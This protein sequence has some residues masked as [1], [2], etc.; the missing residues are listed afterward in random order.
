MTEYYYRYWG[1]AQKGVDRSGDEYHLLAYHA[2]DVAACGWCLMSEKYDFGKR[3]A[4]QLQISQ[5]QL[6][7]LF[8]FLLSIHDLGKF[9]RAFQNLVPHLSEQLTE[10]LFDYQY[11]ER[12]DS[13]GFWLVKGADDIIEVFANQA[14]LPARKV[15]ISATFSCWLQ[16]VMGHHG[17]PPKARPQSLPQFFSTDDIAAAACF[18]KEMLAFWLTQ[19]E[20]GLLFDKGL[21]ARLQQCSWQLAG[22][23]VLADWQ[24]SNQHFFPYQSRVISLSDYYQQARKQATEAIAQAQ[25][26]PLT[27]NPFNSIQ[28]LFPFIQTPTPLQQYAVDQALSDSPQL[29]ILEDV[30]G[31]GKTEA[32]LTLVH[33]MLAQGLASGLYVGLPTMAT[34]NAMY[35]RLAAC[36]QA[37]FNPDSRPSLVLS[38]GARHLSSLFR[39]SV[40]LPEQPKDLSYQNQELSASAYC[41][42]WLA[43]SRKKALLANVGV[44]TL[45]QAL[46]SVLPARHQSLRLL[47][48]SGKVLLVDE[49]HAYDA[50]MQTLLARLLKLHASQGGSAILLS[51]T[52]PQAMK[53]TLLKAYAE[54]LAQPSLELTCSDYP[55]ATQFPA[56]SC[57]EYPLATRAQVCR[58]VNV[59]RLADDQQALTLIK[60]SCARQECV[61]WVR[62]TVDEARAAYEMLHNCGFDAERLTLFHSRFAM[63]D[64]QRIE[65]QVL[66]AFGKESNAATRAGRVLIATQVVEQSLDLDFDLMISDLAP[67]DLML[68]RAGRLHRHRRLANGDPI[69]DASADRRGTPCLYVVS[70]EPTLDAEADWLPKR[71][72][73]RAV[74]QDLALLWRSA[75]LLFGKPAYRMPED[76]RDL[77]ETAY[78]MDTPLDAPE[79]LLDSSYQALGEHKAAIS[80]ANA[81][82]LNIEQGYSQSSNETGWGEELNV[83]TRLSDKTLS[84]VLVGKDEQGQWQPYAQGHEFAW[85]LSQLTLRE[86][87]W[88]EAD[89]ALSAD[90][91]AQ[92][93]GLQAVTP[94]L[95]WHQLFPLTQQWQTFYSA[96]LGWVGAPLMRGTNS[97]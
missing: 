41:N 77:I 38:H 44:G 75:Y 73:S 43:D 15:A 54:G 82:L 55:L 49:V 1:K 90:I 78:D 62:N 32:A 29:F 37:L 33:R 21:R 46:M 81:N 58:T 80:I 40:M 66:A 93:Q 87:Q 79:A 47:G 70:P 36:Y 50:Y 4:K 94:A 48:L 26:A 61:C 17:Q 39:Q 72:G 24:G 69:T 9:A 16:I 89:A 27:A 91:K 2:L 10:S 3:L 11:T 71:S 92:L 56:V 59:S 28:Q 8:A 5:Q 31:A 14:E 45:D 23:A 97:L 96:K 51:A 74:Y 6:Q 52:L 18:V 34:A 22:L 86:K 95:K 7:R 64:R 25:L 85:D 35:Q 60:Q 53:T 65:Q 42:Q 13:L 88:A 67:I 30:T 63:V 83:P 19:D 84:V 76:A 12:H 20:V 57:H 68:Q